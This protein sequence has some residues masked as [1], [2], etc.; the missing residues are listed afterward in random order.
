[1]EF[2]GGVTREEWDF[3]ERQKWQRSRDMMERRRVGAE[4]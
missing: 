1:M 4:Q 3:L 2:N